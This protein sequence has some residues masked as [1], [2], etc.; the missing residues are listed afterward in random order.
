MQGGN[1]SASTQ[2]GTAE[3]GNCRRLKTKG[4]S[5]WHI[6][7][8]MEHLL[9]Y[10][11][12][13]NNMRKF[14]WPQTLNQNRTEIQNRKLILV[15]CLHLFSFL[16]G[17]SVFTHTHS[18]TGGCRVP[19]THQN[20]YTET[21]TSTVQHQEQFG[22]Q[23]VAK[24]K[25]DTSTTRLTLTTQRKISATFF[26]LI[27]SKLIHKGRMIYVIVKLKKIKKKPTKRGIRKVR[28]LF[29]FN[30]IQ[31]LT[32]RGQWRTVNKSAS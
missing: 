15:N 13:S 32:T 24:G 27:H 25:F 19:P 14:D 21:Q 16:M 3:N 9:K 2:P 8:R 28:G 31:R 30:V 1:A 23:Q 10:F 29:M 12:Y 6:S 17:R 18:W 5:I 7:H 4:G 22:V 26:Y 20:F 11:L